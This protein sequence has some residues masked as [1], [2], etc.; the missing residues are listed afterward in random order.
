MTVE[1]G[2]INLNNNKKHL[3]MY[4]QFIESSGLFKGAAKAISENERNQIKAIEMAIAA[5]KAQRW[6][7]VSEE[8]PEEGIVVIGY[9]LL[10]SEV[11]PVMLKHESNWHKLR[12]GKDFELERIKH[13][14]PLPNPPQEVE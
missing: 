12:T 2:I 8:M 5:I 4:K 6:I 14:M 13:W 9:D 1:E 10:W 7:P 11:C 3:E